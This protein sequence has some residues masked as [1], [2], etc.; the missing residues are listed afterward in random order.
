MATAGETAALPGARDVVAGLPPDR[1]AVV[2]SGNRKLARARLQ[3]AGLVPPALVTADDVRRGKPDP[4]P[5]L[6]GARRLGVDPGQCLVIEDAPSGLKAA[7]GAGMR[8]VAVT[9]THKAE[10]LQ[11]DAVI[12]DLSAVRVAATNGRLTV[13]I[14]R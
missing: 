8:T 13:S 5:F 12:A 14:N 4:E 9:T 7:E 1:W 3:A 10:E 6:L 11:A 2:T